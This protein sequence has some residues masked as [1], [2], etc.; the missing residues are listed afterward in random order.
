M[1]PFAILWR[2]RKWWLAPLIVTAVLFGLLWWSE[3]GRSLPS[4]IYNPF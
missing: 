4:Y 1:K 3:S 2:H